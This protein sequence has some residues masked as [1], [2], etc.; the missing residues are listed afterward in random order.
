MFS[1]RLPGLLLGFAW[2][3]FPATYYA[4]ATGGDDSRAGTTPAQSWRTLEKINSHKFQPGDRILLRSGSVWQGHLAP[5]SSGT[6]ESPIVIDRFGNGAR[7]KIDGA[8]RFEDA[9]RLYNVEGIEVRNLE[10]TNRGD[11][12]A[13]RRGV[14]VFLDNFG[15]G[16]HIVVSGLY[17]HDVNGTNEKKDNGGIIFRT[18]GK[19]SLPASMACCWSGTSSGG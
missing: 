13:V 19:R 7:P 14:H 10:V 12:P 16:R 17:I 9:I 15:T 3:A 4:D 6:P 5:A 1:I 2:C 11:A 18:N 8:G